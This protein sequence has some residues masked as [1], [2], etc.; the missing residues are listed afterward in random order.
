MLKTKRGNDGGIFRSFIFCFG[1][2]A[3]T[4]VVLSLISAI[5]VNGLDDPTAFLGIFSLGTMILAAVASGIFSIKI[6]RE[7]TVG[8]SALVALSVVLIMLLPM[9][10]KRDWQ[11]MYVTM[12]LGA[13]LAV[14]LSYFVKL[15]E[16]N[17]Q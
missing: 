13:L 15:Q 2:S 3:L 1:F 12:L 4:I 6:K 16:T 8:Y 11:M 7:S 5:I 17:V 9:V 10:I 14:F